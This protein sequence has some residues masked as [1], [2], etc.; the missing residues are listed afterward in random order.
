MIGNKRMTIPSE[1]LRC[2]AWRNLAI[3][4]ACSLAGCA[5]SDH[6]PVPAVQADSHRT[7][8][9]TEQTKS[10]AKENTNVAKRN[11]ILSQ[12]RSFGSASPSI[13]R[14]WRT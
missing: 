14:P 13:Q 6:T 1:N 10:V 9:K 7:Q 8:Q 3:I 12:S 2:W 5:D 11:L 4:V